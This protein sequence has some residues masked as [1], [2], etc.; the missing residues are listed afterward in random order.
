MRQCPL[1]DN[2]LHIEPTNGWFR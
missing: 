1:Q 2:K